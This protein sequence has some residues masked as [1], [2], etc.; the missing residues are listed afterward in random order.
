MDWFFAPAA[1]LLASSPTDDSRLLVEGFKALKDSY[2]EIIVTHIDAEG[3]EVTAELGARIRREVA[4]KWGVPEVRVHP[5]ANYTKGTRSFEAD[6]LMFS[7][8]RSLV[9]HCEATAR[10]QS[11]RAAA[12]APAAAP[13]VVGKALS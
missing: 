2:T 4:A 10:Q 13:I 8:L 5:V 6:R 12:G 11:A 1:T 7:A 9:K 3:E